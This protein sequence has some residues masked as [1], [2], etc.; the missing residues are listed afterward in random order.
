[1][2][3]AVASG[4][5][6]GP[7][8]IRPGMTAWFGR[9]VHAAVRTYQMSRSRSALASLSDRTL[10]DIGVNRSEIDFIAAAMVDGGRDPI[11]LPP[12]LWVRG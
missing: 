11:R 5:A 4:A 12:S 9:F 6:S 10:K 2:T 8:V 1:M 7:S 3:Y